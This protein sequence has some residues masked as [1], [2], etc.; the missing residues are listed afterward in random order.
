[1][2]FIIEGKI[3]PAVRM[4]QR[5]KWV[6]PQA[7]EYLASKSAIQWQLKNQMALNG[8]TMLPEKTPLTVK[9]LFTVSKRLH[10]CDLDNLV[11]NCMDSA[12]GIVFKDDRWI[13]ALTAE[14]YLGP[15][16]L[17]ILEIGT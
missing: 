7:Q 2:R 17:T 3:K 11:K 9:M 16:Y 5:G 12:Q 4:T 6:D 10:V 8:W 13:D 15:A 1:M 14:R